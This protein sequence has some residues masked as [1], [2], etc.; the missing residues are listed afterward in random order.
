MNFFSLKDGTVINLDAIAYFHRDPKPQ[1]PPRA[2]VEIVF[3]SACRNEVTATGVDPLMLVLHEEDTAAFLDAMQSQGVNVEGI[4]NSFRD[5]L[6]Y[7]A[8]VT[9][10]SLVITPSTVST[11]PGGGGMANGMIT[12]SGPA[13][14]GGT[15]VQLTTVSPAGSA[16][17]LS[18]SATQVTIPANSSS[19]S[20]SI[21][22][23]LPL[24]IS[25]SVAVIAMLGASQVSATVT[26][27]P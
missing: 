6:D 15:T 14:V 19:G 22:S 21:H 13:P 4:R 26:F 8:P 10:Q 3:A 23:S 25:V 12:L 2:Q 18:L 27:T 17:W 11:S 16:M 20:F 7:V 9:I 24:P 5:V 1:T